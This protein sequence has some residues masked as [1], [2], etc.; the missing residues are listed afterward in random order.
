MNCWAFPSGGEEKR[1]KIRSI[2]DKSISV[3]SVQET[4]EIN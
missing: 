3:L 4:P 1:S 2:K